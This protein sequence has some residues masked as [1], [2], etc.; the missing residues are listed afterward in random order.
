MRI[1]PLTHRGIRSGMIAVA[2]AG[3]AF[4][5]CAQAPGQQAGDR[6]NINE[7]INDAVQQGT[8]PYRPLPPSQQAGSPGNLDA[9]CQELA[10]QIAVAPK[11]E[12]RTT[13]PTIE[14]AQGRTVP[15]LER[16]R[17]KKD[18]QK[19]YRDKCAVR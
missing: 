15:E 3:A 7:A 18:L 10:E 13:A 17:P 12:Y 14:T 16:D 8:T 9:E 11:R 4:A 19:A 2:L 1:L 5:A 6:T